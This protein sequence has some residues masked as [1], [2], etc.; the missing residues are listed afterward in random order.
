VTTAPALKAALLEALQAT[1]DLTGVHVQWW[2]PVELPD[3]YERIYIDTDDD[4]RRERGRGSLD[5]LTYNV[6]LVIEVLSNDQPQAIEERLREL[7]GYVEDAVD[8][9]AHDALLI[10]GALSSN[11][12][13]GGW[14]ARVSPTIEVREV[15]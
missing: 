3:A 5:R 12:G 2:L 6:N 7:E 9:L 15:R 4:Y 14:V 13:T 10:P 1:A 11:A 8:G